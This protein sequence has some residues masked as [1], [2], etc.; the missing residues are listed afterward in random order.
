MAGSKVSN[1][2][3]SNLDLNLTG[4]TLVADHVI[5]GIEGAANQ[6]IRPGGD[7]SLTNVVASAGLGFSKVQMDQPSVCAA[8]RPLSRKQEDGTHS[9]T[10]DERK[11]HHGARV[12]PGPL[13]AE[14]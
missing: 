4:L 5:G 1:A 11:E 14:T 2:L 13:F 3:K 12:D 7:W 10:K 6:V 9:G 8:P